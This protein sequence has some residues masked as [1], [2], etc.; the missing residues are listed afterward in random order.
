MILYTRPFLDKTPVPDVS[1]Q[2]CIWK[3]HW[4]NFQES[5]HWELP[6]MEIASHWKEVPDTRYTEEIPFFVASNEGSIL[7]SCATSIALGLIKPHETLDHPPPEGNVISS[8]AEKIKRKD[9]SW[10]NVHLLSRMPKLKSSEEVPIVCSW[11]G[12]LKSNKE[13]LIVQMNNLIIN[14]QWIIETRAVK[15]QNVI[16]S[17]WSP[18]WICSQIDQQC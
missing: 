16:C 10:L 11:D 18:K 3:S 5:C 14:V 4:T 13:N 1:S 2:F 15:L 12:Q 7:M 9:E 6:E 8:N 17:Q